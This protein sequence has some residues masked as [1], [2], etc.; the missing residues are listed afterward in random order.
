MAK[1]FIKSDFLVENCYKESSFEIRVYDQFDCKIVDIK[2]AIGSDEKQMLMTKTKNNQINKNGFQFQVEATSNEF[3]Y[4]GKQDNEESFI[5]QFSQSQYRNKQVTE[6]HKVNYAANIS[7][8]RLKDN[9]IQYI[10]E[11]QESAS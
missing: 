4:I 2:N 6:E 10:E 7:T 8:L 1:D 5:S 9:A 11:N 3:R